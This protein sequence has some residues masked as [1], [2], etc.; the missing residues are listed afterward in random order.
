MRKRFFVT[1]VFLLTAALSAQAATNGSFTV[2][3]VE[4]EGIVKDSNTKLIWQQN[5]ADANEDGTV[6]A[7]PFPAGDKV[8]WQKAMDYCQGLKYA[9]SSDWRLPESS[10]LDSLVDFTRSYPA[11]NPI[12]A[13][14]SDAYWSATTDADMA[15]KAQYVHFNFGSDSAKPKTKSLFVRCV[16]TAK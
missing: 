5:T 11:I 6:T 7:A 10:E 12:F 3:T 14:E 8:P 2:E 4:G 13:C 1:G 15:G 16:R 9:G